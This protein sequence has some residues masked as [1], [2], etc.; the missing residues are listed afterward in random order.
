MEFFFHYKISRHLRLMTT[1]I[2]LLS[3]IACQ[4]KTESDAALLAADKSALA[5]IKR[6]N[7]NLAGGQTVS[8]SDVDS[9]NKLREKYQASAEVRQA[10]QM[11]LIKRGDWSAVEKLIGETSENE[12]TNDER[13]TLA[14]VYFK[15][16]RFQDAAE[17]LKN[18]PPDQ[19]TEL[20]TKSLLGQAQFYLGQPDEAART[21]DSVWE[22][23]LAQKKTDEITLRGMIYFHQGN[24]DQAA[25]TLKKAVEIAPENISANNALSRVYAAKGDTV[26]A[27]IYLAKT[28]RVNEIAAAAEKKKSRLVPL[29]YRLEDAYKAKKFDEVINLARQIL[30]EADEKNRAV[31]YQYLAGAYQAQGK[32]TEAE[33]AMADAAR[34][35]GK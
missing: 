21:I 34:L 33:N 5:E 20:E 9:L 4:S 28:Q 8:Q 2:F 35:T 22:Q 25:E 6:I 1:A 17:T 3:L 32:T 12:R 13:I 27:E 15:L 19:T 7:T 24:L 10:L 31:L 23:I 18:L 26:N 30:P 29:F 16:G 14:K 11:V